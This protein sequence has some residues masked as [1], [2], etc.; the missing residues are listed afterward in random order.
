[1]KH[2]SYV[3]SA[4]FSPDGTRVVT[5]SF[6]K[7]ARLWDARSGKPLGEVMKHQGWIQ[8]AQFSPDGTRVVTAS[9]DKTARL[10]DA[11]SGKPLGE[12]MKHKDAVESAQFSPDG[13]RVVT[14]SS[15]KTARL[16]GLPRPPQ[17]DL[18]ECS[19]EQGISQT[20]TQLADRILHSVRKG[21]LPEFSPVA[22]H[23]AAWF[24]PL[25]VTAPL[26]GTVLYG[27]EKNRASAEALAKWLSDS[28]TDKPQ[29][30]G[31]TLEFVPLL[32]TERFVVDLCEP[33]G[34]IKGEA[35]RYGFV[36]NAGI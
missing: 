12:P 10:W 18:L 32:G 36:G 19:D 24:P 22:Y 27:A 6:D 3:E 1:M 23:P 21:D 28:D 8:S 2:Q 20:M 4:Q 17:L 15:D 31:F 35:D 13:T 16:W 29:R 26:Y 33:L 30:R 25:G 14:A 11:K 7:T 5:A 34:S 9:F